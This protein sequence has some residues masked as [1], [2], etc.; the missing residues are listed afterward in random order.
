MNFNYF[1]VHKSCIPQLYKAL[2]G[3]VAVA[4]RQ[5]ST[6]PDASAVKYK[7]YSPFQNLPTKSEYAVA[8]LDDLINWGRKVIYYY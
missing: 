1:S 3:T 4:A 8:R 6:T 5:Q 7:P 2:S